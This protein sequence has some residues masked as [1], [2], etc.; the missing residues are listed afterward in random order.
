MY[1]LLHSVCIFIICFF[2]HEHGMER[3]H[4]CVTNP[5]MKTKN[6]VVVA[7]CN[8]LMKV[9]RRKATDIWEWGNADVSTGRVVTGGSVT[10]H[11]ELE[12]EEHEEEDGEVVFEEESE[13]KDHAKH[14]A[15]EGETGAHN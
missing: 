14:S 6:P 13:S 4:A 5:M 9:E 15:Q 1:V 11:A 12:E 10:H 2:V 7:D 3:V 8:L